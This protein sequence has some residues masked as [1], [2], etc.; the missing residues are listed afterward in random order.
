MMRVLKR[1]T[2]LED[3][4]FDKVLNRLKV[5]SN[6]LEV[7]V[8]ELAQ[9]V[10][11]RIFDGVKTSELD[12]LAAQMCSSMLI[13]FPDYGVLA[14]RIIV[15]NHHKNTSPSFSETIQ[16]LFEH[17]DG[18]E[19]AHLIHPDVYQV[20]QKN[21]EKLNSSLDYT[22]D[23]DFDY[24]GFKTLE[25]GY[26]MK[27]NGKVVE[28]P[29]HMFMRVALGIHGSDLK[30]ALQTYD[31]MSKKYFVHATPTL[32][33]AGTPRPQCSSCFLV[34]MQDDSIDGIFDTLKD[35]ALISKYAGGIGLHVHNVRARNSTIKGTNGISTGIIPML[36]VY[37]NTARYVNQAGR[38]NGSI[39]IFLEP[40]HADIENFLELRKNHGHEEER[41]RD[42]FY[43][44]WI[45]DL[46]MER[47]KTNE[48]WSLMCPNTCK[49]LSDVYGEEFDTLYKSYEAKGQFI[50]QVPAQDIWFKILESQ[51][52]SGVPYIGFKDHV[53]RK[54]N[55]SNI[56]M[57]KSSNLCMEICEVSK[58]DEIAVCNLASICLPTYIN[59]KDDGSVEFDHSKLH[60]ITKV[61]TKNLNKVIDVNFYPSPKASKSNMSH[62]PIGIGVQGLADTF[63]ILRMPFDSAAA[64]QLNKDIFETMYHG[65]ME[66]SIELAMKFGP[67][68]SF[69]GSPLSEG[70]FQF[71]LWGVEPGDRYDW[72][73]LRSEV[74]QHGAMNSLLIAPMPTASTSQIMGFNECFEPFTSNIYKRKTLAGEFIL[75]NKYLVK[76]L[77]KLNLWNHDIKTKIIIDDGS[78]QNIDE[79]PKELKDIY[80]TVWEIKQKHIIDMAADRGPYVCQ[81]QSMNLFMEAPD[82]SKLSSMHFYSW[83]KGLKT[84]I[85]YLRSKSKAKTQQFTIDPK[86]AHIMKQQVDVHL[87]SSP[88]DEVCHTCSA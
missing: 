52:E 75:V 15:S 80:R 50:K 20:V 66:A 13:D 86:H 8:Y 60:E 78:V 49:G 57:I 31:L 35:C 7:N 46:F 42:L 29:Q 14:S 18:D 23:Y 4:S 79:I 33:N 5:L 32:F 43:S 59:N 65:A 64:K 54:T 71:D 39:A 56:G 28:R 85:Y 3:V 69:K 1:N 11:S 30:D 9:K 61:I 74:I 55:Q 48:K 6:G 47:V 67:Y 87:L 34:A 73:E 84:G 27:V 37:N 25:R 26:L 19:Q 22:R 21:K 51:I 41:A 58:P 72:K 62:R 38:R 53:N 63:A 2:S 83:N 45:P 70:R 77:Q 76:D 24:F 88:V 17:K 82:Y 81:S 16:L 12:E 36:R 44:V 68:S 40:W 10:C